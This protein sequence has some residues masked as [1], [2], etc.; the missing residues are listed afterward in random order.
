MDHLKVGS[1]WLRHSRLNNRCNKI[2]RELSLKI[3]TNRPW[4]TSSKWEVEKL[5]KMRTVLLV[6]HKFLFRK[7]T[8]T[9]L[10]K[11]SKMCLITQN[12]SGVR[13]L[14]TV[15]EEFLSHHHQ[16]VQRKL[17]IKASCSSLE[18]WHQG[19]MSCL[20][21]SCN[22]ILRLSSC[23]L[24]SRFLKFRAWK[25]Y[26][27]I[28]LLHHGTHHKLPIVDRFQSRKAWRISWRVKWQEKVKMCQRNTKKH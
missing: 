24:S 5:N 23:K 7:L 26:L 9:R 16:V 13:L 8:P 1:L 27:R 17:K 28:F 21:C 12:S 2:I 18:L 22:S 25:N 15:A 6:L 20:K 19:W 3:D 10:H 4:Y 14:L 11:N